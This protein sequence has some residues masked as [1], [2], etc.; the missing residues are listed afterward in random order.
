LR[1][2]TVADSFYF[3]GEVLDKDVESIFH[4]VAIQASLKC[5]KKASTETSRALLSGLAQETVT[6]KAHAVLAISRLGDK[7]TVDADKL[8][9]AFKDLV[10]LAD[11]DGTF[12]LTE[13]K[14]QGSAYYAGLA[15][16]AFAKLWSSISE[17]KEAKSK[18][19][20]VV[21]ALPQLVEDA[22]DDG[23][24]SHVDSSISNART[25][26][27]VLKGVATLS[28]AMGADFKGKIPD[29]R[30]VFILRIQIFF[31]FFPVYPVDLSQM[32]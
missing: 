23:E 24:L 2:I 6:D 8:V 11:S 21:A 1:P 3:F 20:G 14:S 29:V 32:N 19:A 31:I 30:I 16:Q 10:E 13:K 9:A 17:N 18:L 5:A 22:E 7:I 27:A 26:A 15:Y 12:K 25:T 4:A 28:K